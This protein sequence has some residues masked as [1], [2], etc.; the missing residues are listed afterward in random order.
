MTSA[1][2]EKHQEYNLGTCFSLG[3]GGG[4][5]VGIG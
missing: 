2:K 4:W 3:G 1:N 5:E